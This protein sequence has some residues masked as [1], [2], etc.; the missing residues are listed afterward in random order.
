MDS[1]HWEKDVQPFLALLDTSRLK[2]PA[3]GEC[4]AHT[5]HLHTYSVLW[6]KEQLFQPYLALYKQCPRFVLS[7]YDRDEQIFRLRCTFAVEGGDT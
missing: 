5:A 6:A 3:N 1:E 2:R 7:N 4:N